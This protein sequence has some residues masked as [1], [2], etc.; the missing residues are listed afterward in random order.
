MRGHPVGSEELLDAF[1]PQPGGTPAATNVRQAVHALRDRLEPG[2]ERQA[3]S[4]YVAGRRGG[5]YELAAGAVIID[6]DVFVAAA[7]AGLTAL[8]D[9]DAARAE[10]AL[11][12]AASLYR[13]DFLADETRRRLGDWPSATACAR[14]PAASCA[15]WPGST[16]APASS[17]PRARTSSAS[18]TSSRSTSTPS[19]RC[20]RSCCAAG[21]ARRRPAATRWS[22]AASAAPSARSRASSSP[23]SPARASRARPRPAPAADVRREHLR[24]SLGEV[25]AVALAFAS[26]LSWGTADFLGGLQ[27]RRRL[28]RHRPVRRPADRAGARRRVRARL[29]RPVP[30][31]RAGARSR[32]A[33]AS[34]AASRWPRS[35]AGWRSGR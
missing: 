11:A 18:P 2:R 28:A 7:E 9:G 8:R 26:S 5:G 25:L 14:W 1:W 27:S 35:T 20:S 30:R 10:A 17:T 19:A 13:G 12:R 3:P 21:G 23:S 32:S 24:L 29:G 34:A 22:A 31:P 15:R 6:A 16:S 4:R 33:P